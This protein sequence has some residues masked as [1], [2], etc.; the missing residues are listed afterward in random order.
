MKVEQ[1]LVWDIFF[2]QICTI[3]FHPVEGRP[4]NVKEEIHFAAEVAD[5]MMVLREKRRCASES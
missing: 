2:A 3:R 5:Q 1:Q 4:L